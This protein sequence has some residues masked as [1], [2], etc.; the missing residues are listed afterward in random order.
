MKQNYFITLE[1]GS[2]VNEIIFKTF[3]PEYSEKYLNILSKN[4]NGKIKSKLNK[5]EIEGLNYSLKNLKNYHVTDAISKIRV[6]RQLMYQENINPLRQAYLSTVN[7]NIFE[8]FENILDKNPNIEIEE[9]LSSDDFISLINFVEENKIFIKK[10]YNKFDL[11]FNENLKYK[12]NLI[13]FYE[14]KIKNIEKIKNTKNYIKIEKRSDDR[15]LDLF[16]IWSKFLMLVLSLLIIE[17][18]IKKIKKQ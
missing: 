11:N 15:L 2:L 16:D 10:F 5:I 17:L 4:I 1:N 12:Y 18:I 14:D 8:R 13:K 6:L 7:A 9:I 3:Y